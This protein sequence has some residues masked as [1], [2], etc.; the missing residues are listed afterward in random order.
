MAYKYSGRI[1]RAGK[2]WRDNDGVQHPSSWMRWSEETKA[3]KGLVWEDDPASFDKRFYWSAGVAKS[4]DD[5]NEVDENGNPLM[6]DGQQLVTKGLKTNA[7]ELVKRQAGDKLAETDWMVIKASEVSGY[8]LPTEV[9]AARAAIRTA[10]NNIEAA[11]LA[12]SDLDQFMALY[13]VPMIDD[14]PTGNAPI[15]DWPETI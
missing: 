15:N 10:S 8:S 3:A 12:A 9:A 11:I 1:I 2:S 14:M 6:Q 5:V 13:D 7:I 4:L